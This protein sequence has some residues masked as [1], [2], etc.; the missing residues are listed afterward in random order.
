VPVIWPT[1]AIIDVSWAPISPSAPC[2]SGT[3]SPRVA[4]TFL[5]TPIAGAIVAAKSPMS[6]TVCS[7][8][9]ICSSAIFDCVTIFSIL[10]TS[11]SSLEYAL[12]DSWS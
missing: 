12:L 3:A 10:R 5:I 6:V 7:R 1:S 2:A 4:L 9:V 11:A 8:V